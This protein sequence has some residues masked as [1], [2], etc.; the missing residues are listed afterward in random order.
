M[1][2]LRTPTPYIP[3]YISGDDVGNVQRQQ[4]ADRI[5]AQRLRDANAD[6][7]EGEFELLRRAAE[8]YDPERPMGADEDG[9]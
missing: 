8:S 9:E 4:E 7:A 3:L 6:L 5:N 2:K 1:K